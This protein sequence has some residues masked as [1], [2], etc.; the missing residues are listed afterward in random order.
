MRKSPIL[1]RVGLAVHARLGWPAGWPSP[2]VAPLLA[3]SVWLGAL[4]LPPCAP[5]L[6][7]AT[8]LT[9]GTAT[10][11]VALT[12]LNVAQPVTVSVQDPVSMILV[13]GEMRADWPDAGVV[14]FR[15]E[16]TKGALVVN[17]TLSGS[18]VR[19][20]DYTVSAG[21]ASGGLL[22]SGSASANNP[23]VS[24]NFVIIP[25]GKREVWM[26]FLPSST[27]TSSTVS[28]AANPAPKT[29]TVSMP[30]SSIAGGKVST[31]TTSLT[32]N[33][34]PASGKPGRK[35]AVR[36]LN[37]AAF[38]PDGDLKNVDSVSALGFE[39]WIDAQMTRPVGTLQPYLVSLGTAVASAHKATAWWNQV[40][41]RSETADSLR[42]RV[43][44]ALSEIFVISD[45]FAPLAA[46]PV[47]MANYYDMLL[48]GAFGNYRDLL[49]SVGTHPCMGTYLSHLQNAKGRPATA[50]SAA[51][52]ADENF[53]REIMQLFSIGLWQLNADGTRTLDAAGQPIPTYDNKT[54]GAMARV[55]TGF[56]FS[57]PKA[58]SF[59]SAPEN[60]TEPMRMW[61]AYHDLDAKV[62]IS[63]PASNGITL[64]ARTA[65]KPDL[66]TAG[67]ADYSAAIDALV[68]HPNTA[69]FFCKQLIQ[70]LVTS[71]PSPQYV[72]RVADK[73]V[74]NGSKVRGD[75]KAVVKAI[76]LDPEARDPKMMANSSFG[77]MKEPY[78]RSVNLAH[79]L[80]AV[81]SS[82]N[83]PL[84]NLADIHFQQ[85]MSAP[86]VFNFFKPGFVPEGP[87]GDAGLVAP[88]FQ[89]LN[90][91]TALF[92]P[93]YHLRA[94]QYG[95][96][97]STPKDPADLVMPQL[98]EEL[99]L[100]ADVPALLR[101][102]DLIL[103]GGS[104]PNAQHQLIREAVQGIPTTLAHWQDE[105]IRMAIY[106]I[107]ASPDYA[108]LR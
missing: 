79:A 64:P 35:A 26:E 41:N 107:V 54:V 105:R 34:A 46:R 19:N 68:Q 18:A 61:D 10:S 58:T 9:A 38:G 74:D 93:N 20:V 94:L 81:S 47:A 21:T 44:F 5:A 27:V 87:I 96:N 32:L 106:L 39:G 102:L 90:D 108:V 14:A 89:I 65:S 31:T 2:R 69:P 55:M 97:R 83:F 85:P 48:K 78:L 22:A 8:V 30:V 82:Q 95:F 51:T 92:I 12:N 3:L 36:F 17:F 67:L 80:G 99:T 6:Q 1:S 25:D 4:L 7:A 98:N 15:R 91:V 43:G 88:E 86:N 13:D 37:Q 62:I 11:Y 40:M 72:K 75:L 45:Q 73:F 84:S 42:Q 49:Y 77:K 33:L 50:T 53:A 66:G 100:A 63:G 29:I 103:M 76:L 56:S 52:F 57:G 71:N 16:N 101:R 59:Y 23:A 28:A 104:L 70:K 60:Y 24:N